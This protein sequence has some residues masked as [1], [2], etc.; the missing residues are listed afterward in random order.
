MF[1]ILFGKL[2][3]TTLCKLSINFLSFLI[4]GDKILNILLIGYLL[5]KSIAIS[6][7]DKFFSDIFSGGIL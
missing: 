7:L 3:L 1:I 4:F 2:S 5:I 6:T